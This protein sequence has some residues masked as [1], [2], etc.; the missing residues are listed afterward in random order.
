M[1]EKSAAPA[2]PAWKRLASRARGAFYRIATP[3]DR[4][5]RW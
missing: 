2:R 5:I 4:L 3:V 1:M